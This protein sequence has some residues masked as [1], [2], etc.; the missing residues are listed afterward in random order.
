VTAVA[1]DVAANDTHARALQRIAAEQPADPQRRAL[2]AASADVGALLELDRAATPEEL[3]HLAKHVRDANG[4]AETSGAI[5]RAWKPLSPDLLFNVPPARRWL[6]RHPTKEGKPCAPGHGDGMFPLGK[7]GLLVADGGVGKT[8]ALIELAICAIV[9]LPWLGHFEIGVDAIGKRVLLVLAEEDEEELHRRAFN[10]ARGMR[11]TDAQRRAVTDR[12]V[13]LPLAGQSIALVAPGADRRIHETAE[14]A[15]LRTKLAEDAGNGWGLIVLDP[16]ARMAEGEI[17]A[18]N[19]GATRAVQALESL[20]NAP[21]NPAVVVSHHASQEG[22][23]TGSPSARGVTAIRN[24]FRWEGTLAADGPDVMFLQTKSNYSRPMAK[25]GLRLMRDEGGRLRIATEHDLEEREAQQGERRNETL[26][27]DVARVVAAV[28]EHG[29]AQSKNQIVAWAGMRKEPG[30]L[31]IEEALS[32]GSLV[33]EGTAREPRFALGVC[34]QTPIPL[35]ALGLEG[36][37]GPQSPGVEAPGL[38]RA[39]NGPWASKGAR[40]E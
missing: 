16:M 19:D 40:H 29:T 1:L 37:P 39:F 33:K 2:E 12:L 8:N 34:V 35:G 4:P 22:V 26:E 27:R 21:G 11:L 38:G 10:G 32:R 36:R 3:A 18:S 6:L 15:V 17:E 24:G 31:A 20:C 25:P 7:A 30:R 23:R 5:E 9:G 14:L 28:T 13:V